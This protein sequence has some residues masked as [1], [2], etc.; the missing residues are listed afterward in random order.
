MIDASAPAASWFLWIAPWAFVIVYAL[1]LLLMP[2]RWARVFGWR[3]D[4][5]DDLAR[6]FGR[7]VGA[8][9]L[10][11]CYLAVRAAPRAHEHALVFDGIAAAGALLALVHV[12]GALERRQPFLETLEIGL[13][14]ALT[15]VALWLRP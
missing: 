1:P 4:E 3:V 10:A 14:V 15:A 7:C 9:A 8:L 13:Y 5:S 2:F 12:W 11:L 6:Y